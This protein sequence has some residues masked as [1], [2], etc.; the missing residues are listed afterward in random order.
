MSDDANTKIIGSITGE[1]FM[2]EVSN[3]IIDDGE[4]WDVEC[5]IKDGDENLRKTLYQMVKKFA[6]DQLRK[7]I[8]VN[9]V[10]ELKKK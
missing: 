8:I 7:T 2:P 5:S 9:F 6:P 3:D 10:D 4:E 1:Y